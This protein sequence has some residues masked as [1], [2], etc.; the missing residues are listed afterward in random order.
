MFKDG[1]NSS[2]EIFPIVKRN[3]AIWSQNVGSRDR[4]VN[5]LDD[6]SSG[7]REIRYYFKC[8]LP[9]CTLPMHGKTYEGFEVFTAVFVKI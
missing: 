7:F 5:T 3:A 4:L 6:A 1:M 9:T 8:Y 2:L